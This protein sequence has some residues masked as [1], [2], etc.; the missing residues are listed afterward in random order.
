MRSLI[1]SYIA[2]FRQQ[3]PSGFD[4]SGVSVGNLILIGGYLMHNRSLDPIAFLFGQL[5][6]TR[7][8][9]R[10]TSDADLQLEVELENGRTVRGQHC[11][12]GKEA[13]Q[14]DFLLFDSRLLEVSNSKIESLGNNLGV[15]IIDVDLARDDRDLNHYDDV[16]LAEALLALT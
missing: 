12:T 4:L 16:K 13:A 7:G 3:M 15:Q 6:K 2:K 11:F 1:Q 14:I 10:T 8:I 9:V 5:I